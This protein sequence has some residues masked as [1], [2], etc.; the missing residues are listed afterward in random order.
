ML[1]SVNEGADN[2]AR[3]RDDTDVG[4]LDK[5][6]RKCRKHSG[7]PARHPIAAIEQATSGTKQVRSAYAN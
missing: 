2:D 5:A 3:G 4:V 1:S 7:G 6:E